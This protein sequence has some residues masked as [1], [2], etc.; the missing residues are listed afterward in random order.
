[1]ASATEAKDAIYTAIVEILEESKDTQHAPKRAEIV[2]DAALAWRYVT[3]GNQPG[4]VQVS[5][6]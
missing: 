6:S 5:S 4:M 2:R 1:M 3:G